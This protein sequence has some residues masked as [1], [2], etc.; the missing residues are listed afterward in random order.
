VLE[1]GGLVLD[2]SSVEL[3]PL[4]MECAD[5]VRDRCET[6]KLGCAVQL[7]SEML[8]CQADR[9]RLRQI[10]S[11]LLDNAVKFTERGNIGIE[12][13]DRGD[14]V[15]IHVTDTGIGIAPCQRQNI[16][17]AFVQLD[18]NLNRSYPG[19]GLGLTLSE[20]L[21]EQHGSSLQ[22]TSTPGEGSCFSF[23]LMKEKP[24]SD[25]ANS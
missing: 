14:K 15:R 16:F 18:A 2:F 9:R 12:V 20:W 11:L 4:I 1:Q 5:M 6:K 10:I 21:V 19:L 25:A 23:E 17:N 3:A 13:E 8:V 24:N 7:P 22:V